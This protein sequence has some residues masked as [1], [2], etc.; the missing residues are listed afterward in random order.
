MRERGA[1]QGS[2]AWG[3]LALTVVSCKRYLRSTL[4]CTFV[5][6][7]IALSVAR[8]RLLQ[9]L[10]RPKDRAV[11]LPEDSLRNGIARTTSVVICTAKY[12]HRQH[13]NP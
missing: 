9:L 1:V 7:V 12:C 6:C 3:G 8:Y 5:T 11:G 2:I 4:H 13:A 10:P